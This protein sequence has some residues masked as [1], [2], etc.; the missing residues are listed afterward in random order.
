MYF[1]LHQL[2][3]QF[4][5]IK[6]Q[7]ME[8]MQTALHCLLLLQLVSASRSLFYTVVNPEVTMLVALRTLLLSVSIVID[9]MEY[10]TVLQAVDAMGDGT[11]NLRGEDINEAVIYILHYGRPLFKGDD[12]TMKLESSSEE[13]EPAP[14]PVPVPAPQPVEKKPPQE[15]VN[16]FGRE[17]PSSNLNLN[18][19]LPDKPKQQQSTPS[20]G[21]SSPNLSQPKPTPSP[22]ASPAPQRT[23]SNGGGSDPDATLQIATGIISEPAPASKPAAA[24][25][26]SGP[27]NIPPGV[28][29]PEEEAL[30]ALGDIDQYNE[31]NLPPG[32]EKG[33]P[34]PH[35]EKGGTEEQ[36]KAYMIAKYEYE[37]FE[38]RIVLWKIKTKKRIEEIKKKAGI[39]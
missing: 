16:P 15:V 28:L 37:T 32:F 24:S 33:P 12:G 39:Q 11:E 23:P 9:A 5:V 13:E 20:A 31:T 18:A 27:L 29:T 25:S 19:F 21:S 22:M 7:V 2:N 35:F 14:A 6:E 36:Y 34:K 26:S 30:L 8:T 38:N 3:E 1:A 10:L 17:A 4:E